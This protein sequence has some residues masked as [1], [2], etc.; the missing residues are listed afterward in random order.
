MLQ[1]IEACVIESGISLGL[2]DFRVVLMYLGKLVSFFVFFVEL[3]NYS[4]ML[5]ADSLIEGDC[6]RVV[7]GYLD[8]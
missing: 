7:K 6:L 5:G 4:I 8:A 3:V 1:F 2:E